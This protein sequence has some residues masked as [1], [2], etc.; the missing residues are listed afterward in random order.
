MRLPVAHR[1]RLAWRLARDPAVPRRAR[2][3]LLGLFVYLAS[4]LDIIPDFIPVIGLL[5]DLLITGIAVW[6]FLRICPPE[7]AI[8]QI[9]R[10]ETT[11]LGRM[12][13]LLPWLLG[14]LLAG[15]FML[16]VVWL[17]RR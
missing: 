7:P 1:F 14:V 8:A 17:L 2:L 13:R 6:W 3:L 4:P 9:E 5:D 12:G 16:F 10:L 15:L 11:P